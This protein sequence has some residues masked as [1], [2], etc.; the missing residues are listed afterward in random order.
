M[1]RV[2]SDR[3][4]NPLLFKSPEGQARYIEAYDAVFSDFRL[5]P[6]EMKVATRFG[7]THVN[8]FGPK[9]APPLMLLH[10]M[11]A[12]STMWAPNIEALR[13][14]FR[15][16]APDT[17]DDLG[18]SRCQR[19]LR[20]RTD[21]IAWLNDVFSGLKLGKTHLAGISYGGWLAFFF[22]SSTTQ[23]VDRLIGIAP[24]ATFQNISPAFFIKTLPILLTPIKK[25]KNHFRIRFFKWLAAVSDVKALE[26]HLLWRQQICG[27]THARLRP[28]L[29]PR[30][31]SDRQLRAIDSP[32]LLL[33]GTRE[34]IYDPQK[35]LY[36]AESTM[37][38]ITTELVSGGTH[39]MSWEKSEMITARMIAFLNE[40]IDV[41]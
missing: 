17:I 19:R 8:A 25:I 33:I 5:K 16:Y 23:A 4:F 32:T 7:M 35:V 39:M 18:K 34:V 22:A 37:L 29:P 13:K 24:A 12:S 9:E 28:I 11:G 31:L 1:K 15:V 27:D 6:E 26:N 10:G 2:K 14:Y 30:V 36:R 3:E 41:G 38:Q 21:Y 20:R 40:Q